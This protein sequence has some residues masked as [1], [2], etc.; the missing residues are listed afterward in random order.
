MRTVKFSL[1]PIAANIGQYYKKSSYESFH[2][3]DVSNAHTHAH[4]HT[5]IHH[6]SKTM[7][8]NGAH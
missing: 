6:T 2:I 1:I 7:E 3:F 5:H 4:T 8:S